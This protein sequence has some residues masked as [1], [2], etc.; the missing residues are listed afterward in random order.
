MLMVMVPC[1]HY[2]VAYHIHGLVTLMHM[3]GLTQQHQHGTPFHHVTLADHSEDG[4]SPSWNIVISIPKHGDFLRYELV[5]PG[6]S[7][8]ICVKIIILA[9]IV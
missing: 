1:I 9:L 3:L 6:L 7:Q 8:N 5:K 2:P 4:S